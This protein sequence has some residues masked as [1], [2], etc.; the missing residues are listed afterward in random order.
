[1][2]CLREVA[3]DTQ[4]LGG[5]AGFLGSHL[6]D[7]LMQNGEE[8]ICLDNFYS[9]RKINVEKWFN[10]NN[11]E[12]VRHDITI[13]INFEVDKIWHLACPASPYFYQLNPIKTSKI[14]FMGTYNMLVLEKK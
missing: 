5:G 3:S 9:G 4:V 10:N 12:L 1:M 6:I 13:P 7:R 2:A 8:V 11:F 14:N